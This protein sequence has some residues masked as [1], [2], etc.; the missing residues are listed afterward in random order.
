MPSLQVVVQEQ[1]RIIGFS[2]IRC[3]DKEKVGNRLFFLLVTLVIIFIFD[4]GMAFSLLQPILFLGFFGFELS[5]ETSGNPGDYK[6]MLIHFFEI[7]VCG[8]ISFVQEPEIQSFTYR[9]PYLSTYLSTFLVMPSFFHNSFI[10]M[11]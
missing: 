11:C 3:G 1:V 2:S 6:L 8:A 10:A 9:I 5:L 4:S 7:I